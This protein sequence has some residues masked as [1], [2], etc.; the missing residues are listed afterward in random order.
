[1]VTIFTI[2]KP[3]RGHTG[4]IQRNAIRSW[5]ALTP[6]PEIILCGDDPGVAETARELGVRHLPEIAR[7]SLGTPLLSSAFAVV[8]NVAQFS[9]VCYVNGDIVFASEISRA[10]NQVRFDRY[11]M[12]GHRWNLDVT[13]ELDFASGW[14]ERLRERVQVE[15]VLH[16]P[17]GIDYFI[18]P[19]GCLG[20]LPEFAVGRPGWDQWMI[21]RAR[22]LRLPV[23]DA[24]DLIAAV[25]QNHDYHHIPQG[26]TPG[27]F[28]GPEGDRNLELVGDDGLRF[29]LHDA[30]Y[31]LCKRGI[32]P[33]DMEPYLTPRL[34]RVSMLDAAPGVVAR[35]RRRAIYFM[36]ARRDGAFGTP[37]RRLI[38]HLAP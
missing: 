27:T 28:D 20:D 19:A 5:L 17:T 13:G 12:V 4:D 8:Q 7:T 22:T 21:Y 33:A 32:T 25:H 9:V 31:R 14:R 23:I 16:T 38:T 11:L 15:G 34:Y 36:S 18:F 3:F 6:K 10:L 26:R 2:P 29:T 1:M 35:L 30:T 24:T 37:F